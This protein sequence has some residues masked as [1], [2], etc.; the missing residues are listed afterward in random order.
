MGYEGI[1]VGEKDFNGVLNT[2]Q[3]KKPDLIF[4]GG[5]YNEGGLLVKQAKDKG[6][7]APL[8]G[9]DALDSS[10]MV[11]IAGAGVEGTLYSSVAGD[12]TK[13]D[14]GKEWADKYEQEFKK[15]PE[16]YSVYAYDSMSVML[17]AIKKSIED[18]GGKLP[19]REKVRDAVRATKDFEGV[20]TKV[21]FDDKGDNAYAKVFIYKFDG[22]AYPGNLISEVSQ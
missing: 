3:S 1:T 12:I 21:S 7:T 6:I 14:S 10:G 9:G 16:G 13:T 22:A 17:E 19:A 15:K 2:V 5:L 18:N 4:F 11:D 20:A 8:M